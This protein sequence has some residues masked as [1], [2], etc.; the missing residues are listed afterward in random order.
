MTVFALY[1]NHSEITTPDCGDYRMVETEWQKKTD[2]RLTHIENRL[3]AAETRDAVSDVHRTNVEKRLTN[4][5]GS[6]TWLVRLIIGAI[7][8]AI[9]GFA[10]QGGFNP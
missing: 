1:V 3:S 9:L 10:L 4:I 8:L 6:L 7:L 2:A 5:E